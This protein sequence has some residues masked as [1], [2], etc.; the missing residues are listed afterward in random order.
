VI[1][2]TA[3]R[4]LFRNVRRTVAVMMTVGLGTGALFCFKSFIQSVLEDYG[5][6]T[7]HSHYGNGQIHTQG[8]RETVL[9]KPWKQWIDNA[10]E[11]EEFASG[12][13]GVQYLFPRMTV[14]GM[15][16][17]KK[18]T[19]TGQGQGVVGERE[20]LFFEG[21]SVVEGEAL[22][23][24]ENGILLG[25]G[26]AR[27]LNVQVGSDLTLYVRS[28]TGKINKKQFQ[29]CGIF[30]TGMVDFDGRVFRIPLDKAQE[31]MNTDRVETIALGLTS[32][33]HWDKAAS[34][35]RQ[36][37]PSLEMASFAELDKV[38]Y[39]NSIDWLQAQFGIVQCIIISMVLL[40]IFNTVSAS[41]LE[42]KQEIG[43]MRANGESSGDI[44]RLIACEG[45]LLGLT[46]SIFGLALS[47]LIAKGIL[48][49]N[50]QMPP[51]PGSN[52]PFFLAFS[53]NM[54]MFF[55]TLCLGTF[56]A[57]TAS[58]LAAVRVVRMPIAKAL[59][60]L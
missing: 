37:F 3:F 17:S 25:Q 1:L 52:K 20:A 44:L 38:Y 12:L 54:P 46:G 5:N 42:R 49:N 35:I 23:T 14:G 56:S 7:I 26:L 22:T 18:S 59:R 10:N 2:K 48:H 32:H 27:S 53:F 13:E 4:N 47:Y 51:G 6:K 15:L 24:Q 50:I 39:Q 30:Y 45:A 34:A 8:Y 60:A 11:I 57:L 36:K 33:T 28:T 31:L 41:I 29:V 40:G 19:I 21:L 55:S 16:S 58:F 9:E 43:S